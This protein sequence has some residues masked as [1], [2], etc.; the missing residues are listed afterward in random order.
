MLLFPVGIAEFFG[1]PLTNTKF[2]PSIL[3]AV[4]FGIGL[5][6]FLELFGFSKHVRGLSLGGAIVI[7][8]V[9]ASVLICWLLFG[10]LSIPLKGRIILWAVGIVVLVIAIFEW[11][12]KS[13]RYDD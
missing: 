5:A 10:S 6:L 11:I 3:G 4:L 8:I 9:G 2:Y 1:L 7:N 13:W 12:T